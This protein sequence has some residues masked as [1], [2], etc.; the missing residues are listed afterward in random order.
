VLRAVLLLAFLPVPVLAAPRLRPEKPA[1]D[2]VEDDRIAALKAKYDELRRTAG[3][4]KRYELA[5]S[6]ELVRKLV[7]IAERSRGTGDEA[8]GETTLQ[9]TLAQDPVRR[10]LYDILMYDRARQKAADGK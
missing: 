2:T 9:R 10:D 1:P 6:A 7:T 4:A 3:P 8:G 5:I